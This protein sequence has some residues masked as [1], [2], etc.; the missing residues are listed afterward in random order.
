MNLVLYFIWKYLLKL[1]YFSSTIVNGIDGI[2]GRLNSDQ[3]NKKVIKQGKMA[4]QMS[5]F[6]LVTSPDIIFPF[7]ILSLV[8]SVKSIC[9]P[10]NNKRNV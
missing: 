9:V 2:V 6:G 8:K 4:F 5:L 7:M 3:C 1:C 10:V